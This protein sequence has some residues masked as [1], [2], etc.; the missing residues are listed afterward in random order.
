MNNIYLVGD[1]ILKGIIYSKE[2]GRYHL[3]DCMKLSQLCEAGYNVV[4][5]SK[6]GA[7]V[8][9]GYSI[10]VNRLVGNHIGDTVIFDFG[11]NDCNF[12][13]ERV[14][15]KD[16]EN[17]LP[18]TPIERFEKCYTDCIKYA[19]SLGARVMLAALVPLDDKKY[20]NWISRGL[21]Y[22]NILSWLGDTSMLY[23]W[24]ESYNQK[25]CEICDLLKCE[26]I[27]IRRPFLLARNY[28]SLM[29]ADGIHPTKEGY[30]IIEST[31]ISALTE[32]KGKMQISA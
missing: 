13:W 19:R 22:E 21:S 1:S 32:E 23:R 11:G 24:H 20:M 4:N 7:T 31:V 12:C 16:T 3:S 15:N 29:C 6:M 14:S 27:D 8:E 2:E 28:G 10:L 18:Y 5:Y 30:K 9:K 17:I 26:K 25:V